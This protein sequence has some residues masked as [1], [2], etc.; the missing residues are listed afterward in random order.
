MVPVFTTK[1]WVKFCELVIMLLCHSSECFEVPSLVC[2]QGLLLQFIFFGCKNYGDVCLRQQ[3]VAAVA[4]LQL[5]LGLMG[6]T[7]PDF[8]DHTAH[9]KI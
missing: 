8:T 3:A 7:L 5:I 1:R 4:R 9:V 2:L 6:A